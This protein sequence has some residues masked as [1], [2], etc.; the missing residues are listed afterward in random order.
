MQFELKISGDMTGL[1]LAALLSG[2]EKTKTEAA[3]VLPKQKPGASKTADP[4]A[5]AP[6][7]SPVTDAQPQAEGDAP[8]YSFEEVRAK[9]VALSKGGKKDEVVALWTA[10]GVA[11]T[12]ELK[13]DQF[14]AAMEGLSKIG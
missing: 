2:L 14:N 4:P 9:A 12:T 3:V 8:K 7:I 1:E 13:P 6:S 5:A 11:K 10:M